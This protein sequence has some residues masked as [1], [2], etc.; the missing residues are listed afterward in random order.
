MCVLSVMLHCI[1]QLVNTWYTQRSP[2]SH[3]I[4]TGNKNIEKYKKSWPIKKKILLTKRDLSQQKLAHCDD[5]NELVLTMI[6]S[7]CKIRASLTYEKS[8]A[9]HNLEK[10]KD[11]YEFF[12][13]NL[14]EGNFLNLILGSFIAMPWRYNY[15]F[16]FLIYL[17]LSLQ[18]LLCEDS[19]HILP[20]AK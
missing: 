13:H 11:I 1:P 10:I 18:K 4:N 3:Y 17:F 9:T 16:Y 2:V 19:V 15:L 8:L 7:S 20:F 5:I 6:L 12:L 14:H